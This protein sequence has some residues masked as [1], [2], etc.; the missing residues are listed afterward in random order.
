MVLRTVWALAML[1]F[2][3]AP[4]A[5]Q[6]WSERVHVSVNAAALTATQDFSDRFEFDA[7]AETGSTSVD[8]PVKGGFVF[9]AG[10]GYRIW[11]NLGA[12]VAVSAF[13]RD[14]VAATTTSVPH[15]FFFNQPRELSGDVGDIGRSETGVHVQAIYLLHTGGR[16]RVVL[17]AGPSFLAVSQDLVTTVNA[18]ETYPFDAA[19]FGSA[20]R[21]EANGSGVGFNAGADVLWMLGRQVGVGGLVR[22]SKASV[23]L[24]AANGRQVSVD[25]GGVYAGGGL[26]LVF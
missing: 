15:P 17:S 21:R 11:K 3:T 18:I 10:L 23:D 16:L 20:E 7:N 13:S 24:D 5:A 26:R 14:N 9:D 12:G 4:A 2:V 8:Y 25:G 22:F 1:A 6:T 19:G